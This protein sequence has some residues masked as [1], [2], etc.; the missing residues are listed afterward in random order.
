MHQIENQQFFESLGRV[1]ENTLNGN[2]MVLLGCSSAHVSNGTFG[3]WNILPDLNPS[4][5][6]GEERVELIIW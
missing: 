5:N 3:T 1:L 6:P 4:V 2:S